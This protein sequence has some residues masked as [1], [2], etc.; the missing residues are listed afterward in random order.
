MENLEAKI[1]K[2]SMDPTPKVLNQGQKEAADG[3]FAFLF[4][5]EKE[6][7]ITG[8]GG[9]GKTFVMAH[10]IDEVLP[11]YFEMCKMMGIKPAFDS[12]QMTATTNKAAE[13]LSTATNRHADTIHSLMNLKVQDDYSTGK[14]KLTKT[15]AWR[16]HENKII[17][18]DE[19]S[20]VDRDL[21]VIIAEG[22]QNCK[23]VY[24]GDHCQLAPIAEPIS[25]VY[26]GNIHHFELTEQMRN[27]ER[28]ALM[29]LCKQLRYTVESGEFYP[30]RLVPGV[31]DMLDDAGLESKIEEY[32]KDG[33]A[34]NRILAYTNN[35]VIQ[36]N[37][38]I[39]TLR[40]L[41]DEFQVGELL[42][43]NSAIRL[44]NA[45]LSVEEGI[46]I[47]HQA[48][49]TEM[50]QIAPGAELEIRKTTFVTSLSETFR[51]IPIPVD[52]HH[53]AKLIAHYRKAKN[54][55]VYCHLKN[56]YPDLRQRDAATVHKSQG[57]T[58]D[59]VF[60]DL[61]NISTCNIPNQV[62]RM[63]YVAASRPRKRIFLYGS[64]AEKYG[65]VSCS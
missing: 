53:F 11:R 3:F 56:S 44:R 21:K 27:A 12:V 62:A 58:Y 64:L 63:L 16:V 31:I 2:D 29:D 38:H 45:M 1:A 47:T 28:P 39:R 32:F 35:R 23:I 4:N 6:M 46:E 54:W 22:T 14:S 36:Y 17:F 34:N 5:E 13:V 60:I 55:P 42:V 18:I 48:E 20:L 41:P 26:T 30:I 8:P 40:N 50:E 65:G 15:T 52:R 24:V 9:V 19:A 49:T 51:D 7:G 37:D 59:T 57:S 33:A 25:P 10:L 61:G 43:N